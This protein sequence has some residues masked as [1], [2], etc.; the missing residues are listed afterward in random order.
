MIE[1]RIPK[2]IQNFQ[3]KF[4]FNLT[5]RQIM[6]IVMMVAINVP[7]YIFIRGSVGDSV[8]GFIVMIIAAPIG[9]YG[10]FRYNGMPFEKVFEA[11]V[12][13][14]FIYPQKRVYETE[15]IYEGLLKE[16]DEEADNNG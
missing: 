7:L 14:M 5:L 3:E 8:A 12:T 2:E 11:A 9:L 1:I 10:F 6:S 4:M 13:T 16:L 15:N